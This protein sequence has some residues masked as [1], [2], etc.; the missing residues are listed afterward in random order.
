MEYRK[1]QKSEAAEIIRRFEMAGT[2][3]IEYDTLTSS[4]NEFR[5]YFE[6]KF[7]SIENISEKADYPLGMD[8]YTELLNIQRIGL[9]L[10]ADDGFWRNLSCRVVPDFV[11]RRWPPSRDGNNG[12]PWKYSRFY[13]MPQRNWLKIIWWMHHLSWQGDRDSTEQCLKHLG[14]DAI[15]QVVERTGLGYRVPLYRKIMAK[16]GKYEKQQVAEHSIRRA[17]KLNTM[18]I[19]TLIPEFYEGGID[20]YVDDLFTDSW[21][22]KS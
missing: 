6:E 9:R 19:Q 3:S 1:L 4:E 17:M 12:N 10:A 2:V 14:S 22:K 20:G 16:A 21:E 8:L 5:R 7:G 11:L 13:S 18:R 15:S